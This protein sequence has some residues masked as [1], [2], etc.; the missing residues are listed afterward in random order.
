MPTFNSPALI[1][2]AT[3][4]IRT[5][6]A[7]YRRHPALLGWGLSF[8][9]TVEDNYPGPAYYASWGIYDYSPCAIGRFREW[10]RAVSYTHLTLPTKRIV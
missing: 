8:G 9:W 4:V 5:L 6:V 3:Q 2:Y 1:K 10:L 7:R